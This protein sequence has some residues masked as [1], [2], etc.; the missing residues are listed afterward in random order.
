MGVADDKHHLRRQ[1][2]R[3]TRHRQQLDAK[4]P[5][6]QDFQHGNYFQSSSI[7]AGNRVGTV[8]GV[9]VGGGHRVMMVGRDEIE[10]SADSAN[11]IA[12]NRTRSA[13]Q[14]TGTGSPRSA[15]KRWST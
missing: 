4:R 2:P 7:W 5:K 11:R 13:M 12:I 15:I 6:P 1:P 14:R 9:L 3:Q 8:A 10:N